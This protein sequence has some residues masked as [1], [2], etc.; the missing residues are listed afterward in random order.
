VWGVIVVL[1][2]IVI[3]L[4]LVFVVFRKQSQYPSVALL[5]TLASQKPST[6]NEFT[7][8]YLL[9]GN[10]V[11]TLQTN[12]TVLQY[13]W[14]LLGPGSQGPLVVWDSANS[15]CGPN[16]AAY[17]LLQTYLTTG[18]NS[19]TVYNSGPAYSLLLGTTTPFVTP[20]GQLVQ[21]QL[22]MFAGDVRISALNNN[23]SYWSI[24][25][26]VPPQ[27]QLTNWPS[28]VANG[29][30]T[31]VWQNNNSNGA[32]PV[33]YFTANGQLMVSNTDQSNITFIAN[34]YTPPIC[35]P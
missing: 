7:S 18:G 11:W 12:G 25:T 3:T 24:F 16:A 10:S 20:Q 28:G 23:N 9:N 26:Q 6:L 29:F 17:S 21:F 34:A 13:I 35:V 15:Y 14:T 8:T 32:N 19:G 22:Q 2:A 31:L 33:T 30:Q 1:L 27:F 4:I 5:N